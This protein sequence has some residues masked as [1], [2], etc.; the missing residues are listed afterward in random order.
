MDN[1]EVLRQR[2]KGPEVELTEWRNTTRDTFVFELFVDSGQRFDWPKGKPYPPSRKL[3]VT[4]PPKGMITPED[5]IV[6]GL[7]R[8]MIL[9]SDGTVL[10][11]KEYD[12]G[13]QTLACAHPACASKGPI[14]CRD[15]AHDQFKQI[16]GGACP[17][18]RRVRTDGGPE[19]P[20]SEFLKER[21]PT[22]SADDVDGLLLAQVKRNGGQ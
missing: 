16:V 11:P 12:P 6:S 14:Y 17:Q 21:R 19:A 4:V 3:R 10:L 1:V 18:L 5:A 2:L 22:L 20:L 9:G 7:R 13:V 8:D 15:A